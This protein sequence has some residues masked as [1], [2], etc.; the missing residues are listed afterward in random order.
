[1]NKD[2]L[3]DEP[4]WTQIT[5]AYLRGKT[6]RRLA[7]C[8]RTPGCSYAQKSI[9]GGCLHCELKQHASKTV[10]SAN[11]VNQ[12][13]YAL[14]LYRNTDINHLDLF[15]LGSFF[16]EKEVPSPARIK[17]LN[18]LS[19]ENIHSILL[20][21][22]PEYLNVS[23]VREAKELLK[24]I[25]L[26]IGLGIESVNKNVRENY[27]KK[28]YN[29]RQIEKTFEKLNKTKVHIL[30]YV[31]LKPPILNER[32]AIEDSIKTCRYV[33]ELG[34]KYNIH[35]RIALEPF[36]VPRSN[37]LNK[38]DL[39]NYR[40]PYLWSIIEVIKAIHSY[41]IMFVG[42]NDEGLSDNKTA[43]NCEKCNK[44]VLKAIGYFNENQDISI[45]EGLACIC[46]KTW[47][48]NLV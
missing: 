42:I 48:K 10:T 46:K 9:S 6:K 24:D 7:I 16:D 39:I 19:K 28:G 32:Q 2:E 25:H 30:G 3:N 40:P 44:T 20:E 36:Y 18:L 1:M 23:V 13:E 41:G 21:S 8:L 26:E 11:L 29:L 14:N 45:F 35:V 31:L 47:G 15:V 22:R 17:I 33:F 43:S 37:R 27:L 4:V 5:G 12:I 38:A 34:K